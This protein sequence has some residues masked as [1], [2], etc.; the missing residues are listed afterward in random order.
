MHSAPFSHASQTAKVTHLST[1]QL[2]ELVQSQAQTITTLKHKLEW[3]KRQVFGN[4]SERFAP[5]ADPMQLHL[6]QAF[7]VPA[8]LPEARKGL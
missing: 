8:P 4:K 5:E 6:G 3:F 2:T 1:T 7:P